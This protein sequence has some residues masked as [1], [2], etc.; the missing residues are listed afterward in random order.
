VLYK[1]TISP[2]IKAE[3]NV[4]VGEIAFGEISYIGTHFY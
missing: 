3:F 2:T 4:A 1:K